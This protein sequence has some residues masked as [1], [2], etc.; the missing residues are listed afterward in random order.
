MSIVGTKIVG[1][2]IVYSTS[3]S[4]MIAFSWLNVMIILRVHLSVGQKTCTLEA[5]AGNN[6]FSHKF[7]TSDLQ[8]L[9]CF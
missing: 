4:S 1:S 2:H 5:A 8:A 3:P 9:F 6:I 7:H